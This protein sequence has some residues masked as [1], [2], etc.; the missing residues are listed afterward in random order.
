MHMTNTAHPFRRLIPLVALA[1]ASATI[2]LG[3]C[4]ATKSTAIELAMPENVSALAIDVKNF[5][6]SVEVRADKRVHAISIE[7]S[8]GV[9]KSKEHNAEA[10]LAGINVNADVV[11]V[12][13]GRGVLKVV[14][15]TG[16]PEDED[17]QVSLTIR[18]PKCDGVHVDNR[19]GTVMVVG[20]G[21]ALSITNR[22][23]AVEFR[24]DKP[25][26]DPVSITTTDGNIYYQIPP[27]SSGLFDLQTLK[28]EC[29]YND[30]AT[31]ESTDAY[32]TKTVV[33]MRLADGGNPV[34]ARTNDGDIFVYVR[35]DPIALTRV[36][37]KSAPDFNDYMW[38][39]GSQRF[40]RNLPDN[41]PHPF[42][43]NNGRVPSAPVDSN[44]APST[45]PVTTTA[46]PATH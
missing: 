14:T 20:T 23:G 43:P 46:A 38:L 16:S 27:G 5:R 9:E 18:V 39:D 13:G 24:T 19:G 26:T 36:I 29:S 28:G 45:A 2:F 7:S 40:M 17:Q 1:A 15:T 33:K 44:P 21:G 41:E 3:G 25:I 37:K 12:G 6:G 30:R 22:V 35:N 42:D 34:V 10:I 4:S 31:T 32:S 11:D 8:V